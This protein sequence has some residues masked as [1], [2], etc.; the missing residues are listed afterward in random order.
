MNNI[1]KIKKL[2]VHSLA[3]ILMC[4]SEFDDEF[5]KD[6]DMGNCTKCIENWLQEEYKNGFEYLKESDDLSI[7]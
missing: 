3:F 6:W 5:K 7:K 4:P 2:N 1:D